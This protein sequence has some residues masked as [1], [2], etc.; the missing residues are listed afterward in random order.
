VTSLS[1]ESADVGVDQHAADEYGQSAP[2][3]PP[4]SGEKLKT[5]VP[6]VTPSSWS[7]RWR[8]GS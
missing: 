2:G 5:D 8:R 6:P 4:V 7:L 3:S 1:P